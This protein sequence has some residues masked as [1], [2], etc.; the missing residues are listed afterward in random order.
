MCTENVW[1]VRGPRTVVLRAPRS[2]VAIG[3]PASL[4]KGRV[5]LSSIVLRLGQAASRFGDCY[6]PRKS[7]IHEAADF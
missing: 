3:E 7:S 6:D 2:I 4:N 5:V 1:R